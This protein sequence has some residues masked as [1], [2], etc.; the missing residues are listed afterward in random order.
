MEISGNI[1]PIFFVKTSPKT[2]FIVE[3]KG[4][5]DLDDIRKIKR[6]VTWCIDIDSV[7]VDYSYSPVYVKQEDWDK[8]NR[9]LKSFADL[10]KVFPINYDDL[11]TKEIVRTEAIKI[12][13]KGVDVSNFGDPLEWQKEVR[14]DRKID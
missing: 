13:N 8:K 6:L 4:R 11:G 9:D 2:F 14:K 5:Q 10:L 3:T 7:Q 1:I 12:L